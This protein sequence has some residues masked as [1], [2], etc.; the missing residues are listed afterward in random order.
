[1]LYILFYFRK[2]NLIYKW[3]HLYSKIYV[4]LTSFALLW[5]S[6]CAYV[7]TFFWLPF[8]YSARSM[9]YELT[10]MS[11]FRWNH[12]VAPFI[13]FNQPKNIYIYIY[14][15]YCSNHISH[16][17]FST[18]PLFVEVYVPIQGSE[19]WCVWR[20]SILSLRF[21]SWIFDLF[22]HCLQCALYFILF[23][24]N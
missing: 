22:R 1:V 12:R 17:P 15:T 24:Q 19:R 11:K 14:I 5:H 9:K 3:I 8:Y 13:A 18:T 10:F 21:F 4:L 6:S 2:I 16:K 23:P 20:I 7:V